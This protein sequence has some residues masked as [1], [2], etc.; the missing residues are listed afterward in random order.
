MQNLHGVIQRLVQKEK[1]VIQLQAEL[2]IFKAQNPGESRDLVR[3]HDAFWDHL[4][5]YFPGR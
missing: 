4:L 3:A 5:L 2:E 1:Q